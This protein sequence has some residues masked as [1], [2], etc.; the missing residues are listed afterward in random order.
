[1]AVKKGKGEQAKAAEVDRIRDI[2]FGNEMRDYDRRFDAVQ[3]ELDGLR[4]EL[5]RL[6]SLQADSET[7]VTGRVQALREEA[8]K[9]DED[10]RTELRETATRLSGDTVSRSQLADL[11]EAMAADLRA[12]EKGVAEG[13]LA[14]LAEARNGA[15]DDS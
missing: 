14:R 8:R 2:I 13:L 15:E 6:R 1:M 4:Q 10:L 5:D 11:L 12:G 9:A 7:S 3:G